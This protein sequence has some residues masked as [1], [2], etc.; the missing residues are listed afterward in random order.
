MDDYQSQR[1]ISILKFASDTSLELRAGGSPCTLKMQVIVQ[2]AVEVYLEDC[3]Q[4]MA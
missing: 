1:D 4:A 2:S 3:T